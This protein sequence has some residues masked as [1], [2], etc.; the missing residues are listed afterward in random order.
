MSMRDNVRIHKVVPDL[1]DLGFALAPVDSQFLQD[2]RH[3]LV[4]R[5]DVFAGDQADAWNIE[6]PP[7]SKN[8]IAA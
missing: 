1:E 2:P 6:P 3:D 5:L 8:R 4:Q 7:L